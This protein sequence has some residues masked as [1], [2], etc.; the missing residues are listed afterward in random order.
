[1][2]GGIPVV[3]ADRKPY[4]IRNRLTLCRCGKSQNKPFCDGSHAQH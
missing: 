3:S 4:H 2:R 1:M